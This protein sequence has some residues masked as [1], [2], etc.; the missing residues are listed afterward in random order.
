MFMK[1]YLFDEKTKTALFIQ[2]QGEGYL[3]T[4]V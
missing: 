1:N 4:K 3:Q 2:K